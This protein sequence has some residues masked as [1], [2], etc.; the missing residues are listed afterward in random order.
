MHGNNHKKYFFI[1]DHTYFIIKLYVKA[2]KHSTAAAVVLD[3]SP[4]CIHPPFIFSSLLL[5]SLLYFHQVL[6]YFSTQSQQFFHVNRQTK[7]KFSIFIISH[8]T[9]LWF[10]REKNSIYL[11]SLIS[12]TPS[13]YS[14]K[15]LVKYVVLIPKSF[16]SWLEAL[17]Q[18]WQLFGLLYIFFPQTE[19]ANKQKKLFIANFSLG[20]G[21]FLLPHSHQILGSICIQSRFHPTPSFPIMYPH[22]HPQQQPKHSEKKTCKIRLSHLTFSLFL[23]TFLCITKKQGEK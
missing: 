2:C 15:N 21:S 10:C 12:P 14:T 18:D 6:L 16:P 3:Y 9:L 13:L 22:P 7:R 1:G 4:M 8:Q 19:Q 17:Q 11:V 5:F 20:I 23:K